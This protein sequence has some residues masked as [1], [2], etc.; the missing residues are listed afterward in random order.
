MLLK[1]AIII[2][3]LRRI[4]YTK[5][6]M[7]L[8]LDDDWTAQHRCNKIMKKWIKQETRWWTRRQTEPAQGNRKSNGKSWVKTQSEAP[9]HAPSSDAPTERRAEKEK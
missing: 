5:H 2:G 9:S 8:T 7:H 6:H 1:D 3:K 4:R